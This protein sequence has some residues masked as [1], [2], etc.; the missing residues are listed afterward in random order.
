[1]N[2]LPGLIRHF[3]SIRRAEKWGVTLVTL[4]AS[5]L[6]SLQVLFGKSSLVVA[7]PLRGPEG[8]N[9]GIRARLPLVFAFA[10]C[11]SLLRGFRQMI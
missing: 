11:A 3:R 8:P 7:S 2:H 9:S 10:D 6:W 4:I 1:M 5:L